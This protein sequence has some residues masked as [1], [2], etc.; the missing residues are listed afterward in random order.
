MPD[1][2]INMS[3]TYMQVAHTFMAKMDTNFFHSRFS[4]LRGSNNNC[5]YL[6]K[7]SLLKTQIQ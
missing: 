1:F 7:I 2:A 3:T 5:F 6:N 4:R